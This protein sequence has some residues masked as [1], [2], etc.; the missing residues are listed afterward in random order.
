MVNLISKKL[1]KEVLQREVD[2][3]HNKYYSWTGKDDNDISG[4]WAEVCINRYELAFKCKELALE[5]GYELRSWNKRCELIEISR[6]YF[7]N[8]PT[9][10]A[11]TELEAII[12]ACEYLINNKEVK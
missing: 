11:E 9:I 5:L 12:K 8:V 2:I 1:L 4:V 3:I 10:K 7:V 6:K